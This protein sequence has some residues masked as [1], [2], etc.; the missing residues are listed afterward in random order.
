MSPDE[1]VQQTLW[2]IEWNSNK[3]WKTWSWI[4]VSCVNLF[5][6]RS[7]RFRRAQNDDEDEE[8]SQTKKNRQKGWKRALTDPTQASGRFNCNLTNYLDLIF[9]IFEVL[10]VLLNLGIFLRHELAALCYTFICCYTNKM[11]L[12][13]YQEKPQILGNLQFVYYDEFLSLKLFVSTGLSND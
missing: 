10:A 12:F 6:V 2:T 7:V 4:F 3:I 1:T 13:N 11:L 8:E 9:L 5:V